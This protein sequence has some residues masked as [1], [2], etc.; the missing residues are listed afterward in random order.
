MDDVSILEIGNSA[1]ERMSNYFHA[2]RLFGQFK[3]L[4]AVRSGL[5]YTVFAGH[6]QFFYI[7]K[8]GEISLV[9]AVWGL[10]AYRLTRQRVS[11]FL[12]P[13][14]T[15]SFHY[16]YDQFFYLSAHEGLGLLFLGLGMHAFLSSLRGP[17]VCGQGK[18]RWPLWC[19]GVGLLWLGF[20][21]KEPFV[22]TGLACALAQIFLFWQ[23]RSGRGAYP[24]L[25]SALGLLVLTIFYA[26]ALKLFVQS[27]YTAGYQL[28]NAV[29]L[30]GNATAWLKKDV[31]NHLPWIAA[32]AAIL[33]WNKKAGGA[34]DTTAVWGLGLA[35]SLYACYL[36]ILLPWNT[37]SYYAAPL[38]IFF[39]LLVTI[40]LSPV[41]GRLRMPVL[42][43]LAIGSLALNLLV[44]QYAL[45]REASYQN[46]TVQLMQW[47][48]AVWE[49]GRYRGEPLAV[50]S[51]AMEPADA[52]PAII[53]RQWGLSLPRFR[54]NPNPQDR[55]DLINTDY[56]LYSPRFHSVDLNR[57]RDW[58]IVFTS[59][60]WT[61]FANNPPE[62]AP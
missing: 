52:I 8:V 55:A 10:V 21:S 29:K 43:L 41:M 11:L 18:I 48:K 57:F 28:N 50:L 25:W 31:F 13:A 20:W 56:Y 34:R 32:V 14:V 53:N 6:P 22:S 58:E 4:Y 45:T 36:F 51:N 27:S 16:F 44:C 26:G 59:R 24:V 35:A 23:I 38:G 42:Y 12:L 9:L 2:T 40:L 19:L 1:W 39:A 3:P 33:F 37:V 7:F 17:L 47:F 62:P 46:D 30:L 5:L 61:V 49:K 60:H 15:L 54:W